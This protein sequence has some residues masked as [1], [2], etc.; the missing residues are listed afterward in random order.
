MRKIS[1]MIGALALGMAVAAQAA[2]PAQTIEARQKSLK[3]IG[4]AMKGA[5]DSFKSGTPDAAIIKASATTIAGYAD[6]LGTWFPKGTGAE[7]GVKTAAKPEIWTDA[8]GFKKAA[9]DF[10]VAAKAF[11]VAADSGD[12]AASGKALGALGGTCK[13]CHE[14]FKNK[15]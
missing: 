15:D 14:K 2:A 13:G 4:K 10:S 8:A 1:M 5:G 9:G 6:K 12:L 11:K 3:E 7:A